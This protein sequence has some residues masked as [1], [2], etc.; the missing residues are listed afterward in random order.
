MLGYV[1]QESKITGVTPNKAAISIL[2]YGS[3]AYEKYVRAVKSS[4]ARLIE[5]PCMVQET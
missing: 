5:S 4:L 3:F 1:A 2:N